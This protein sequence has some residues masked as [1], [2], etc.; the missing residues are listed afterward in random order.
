MLRYSLNDFV[1]KQ[2]SGPV[3][4]IA[5]ENQIKEWLRIQ[6]NPDHHKFYTNFFFKNDVYMENMYR[7]NEPRHLKD[8]SQ[9]R[10]T[11]FFMA[12]KDR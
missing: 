9:P 11:K 3:T 8:E 10:R 12:E 4:T 6:G 7:S 2:A 5:K 1:I